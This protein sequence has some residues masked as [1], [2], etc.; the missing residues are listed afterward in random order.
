[1]YIRMVLLSNIDQTWWLT[2]LAMIV[3]TEISIVMFVGCMH[4]ISRLYYQFRGPSL[5]ATT[6]TTFSS[7][8]GVLTLGGLGGKT[9]DGKLSR[10]VAKYMGS[11]GGGGSEGELELRRHEDVERGDGAQSNHNIY[12]TSR[13]QTYTTRTEDWRGR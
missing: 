13:G 1:M 8:G 2:K 9:G 6:T 4:F 3:T 12:K 7:K 11:R 5:H 10:T